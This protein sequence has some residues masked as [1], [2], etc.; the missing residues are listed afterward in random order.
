[1]FKADPDPVVKIRAL[2][3]LFVIA[4]YDPSWLRRLLHHEHESVRAWAIR[5]LTDALP[6]DTVDSRRGGPDVPI[7]ADDERE[8][9]RLARAD[10]SGLVRLAH[11]WGWSP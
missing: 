8:L 3:S 1:M 11:V 6:I 2:C 9:A 5:F 7:S 4:G 10:S